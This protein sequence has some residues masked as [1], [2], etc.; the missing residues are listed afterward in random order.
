VVSEADFGSRVCVG[1]RRSGSRPTGG[2]ACPTDWSGTGLPP[3]PSRGIWSPTPRG[4][5]KTYYAADRS[6]VLRLAESRGR[7][8]PGH[9]LQ[10]RKRSL[11]P[12]LSSSEA[13][14]ARRQM[15]DR[16][17]ARV[18]AGSYSKIARAP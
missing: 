17:Q 10:R 7:T 2:P 5:L 11:D 3:A 13:A 15:E 12:A 8:H 14:E 16:V 4:C 6:N 18:F 1:A 9:L